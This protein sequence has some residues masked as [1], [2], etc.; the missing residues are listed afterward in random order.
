[1]PAAIA[2]GAKGRSARALPDLPAT[3]EKLLADIHTSMFQKALAFRRANT[4]ETATYEELKRAVETGFA[5]AHWCGSGECEE[6]IKEETRA[7]MR[8]IPLDQADV[9]GHGRRQR[10][11]NLR[12]LRQT[13]QGTGDFRPS[14]LKRSPD[15]TNSVHLIASQGQSRSDSPFLASSTDLGSRRTLCLENMVLRAILD[16]ARERC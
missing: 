2:R 5:F 9:L 1:M 6:K 12:A 7:T 11:R 14:I 15:L 10:Q 13:R 4:H 3:I 16:S 8:C